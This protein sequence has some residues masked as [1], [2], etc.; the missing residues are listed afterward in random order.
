VASSKTDSVLFADGEIIPGAGPRKDPFQDDL[1]TIAAT[2]AQ[3]G[4]HPFRSPHGKYYFTFGNESEGG[5]KGT[6]YVLGDGVYRQSVP[7]TVDGTPR[8]PA[9]VG[10]DIQLPYLPFARRDISGRYFVAYI[11][12]NGQVAITPMKPRPQ[13]S[14]E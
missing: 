5:P 2:M 14:G 1:D 3:H 11:N 4:Y 9:D 12:T 6:H 7:R 13:V 8:D 10:A